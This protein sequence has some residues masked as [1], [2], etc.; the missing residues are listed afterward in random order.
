MKRREFLTRTAAAA[1]GLALSSSMIAS[2]AQAA[3]SQ[4]RY[5]VFCYF[6]GGWDHL[7]GLDPR[8]P[9]VFTDST[10]AETGIQPAFDRLP[11]AFS[12]ELVKH[13]RA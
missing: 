7:L 11:A 13:M 12:K 2:L 6:E 4:D 3:E 9:K 10:A 1:G 5:Y 8:D